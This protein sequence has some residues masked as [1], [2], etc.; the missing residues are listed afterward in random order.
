MHLDILCGKVD[1][2][3]AGFD[4]LA[5]VYYFVVKPIKPHSMIMLLPMYVANMLA[6]YKDAQ[7]ERIAEREAYAFQLL[8]E[9]A[10]QVFY[11]EAYSLR[12]QDI[13]ACEKKSSPRVEF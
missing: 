2:Y 5:K 1:C 13:A 6:Q 8:P 4:P 9:K 3:E 11:K 7:F 12:Q 10:Q